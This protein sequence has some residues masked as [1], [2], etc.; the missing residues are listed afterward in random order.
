MSKKSPIPVRLREKF[1]AHM[2]AAELDELPDGAWWA[3]QEEA[4]QAF[5]DM[6]RL[7]YADA[8]CAA[9]QWVRLKNPPPTKENVKNDDGHL[10]E[11]DYQTWMRL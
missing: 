1:I 3:V 6:H 8:N 9:H 10:S 7:K 4:A 2:D 11:A 5:I